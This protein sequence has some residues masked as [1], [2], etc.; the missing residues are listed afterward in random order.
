[1]CKFFSKLIWRQQCALLKAAR[2]LSFFQIV[3][4]EL[5]H[6]CNFQ[7]RFCA[8]HDSFLNKQ[9]PHILKYEK[10]L[11]LSLFCYCSSLFV[12]KL[13]YHANKNGIIFSPYLYT[14]TM[15][16]TV[17]WFYSSTFSSLLLNLS[18]NLLTSSRCIKLYYLPYWLVGPGNSVDMCCIKIKDSVLK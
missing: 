1:M 2:S 16:I 4:Y 3:E 17:N 10:T 14:R 12:N 13:T 18:T 9:H 7:N 8:Y 15:Q 11:F 5:L 6:A